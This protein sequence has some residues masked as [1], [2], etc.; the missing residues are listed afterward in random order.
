MAARTTEP[1]LGEL[2]IM[3]KDLDTVWDVARQSDAPV[4]MTATAL[5]LMRQ[6]VAR[7]EAHEDI[8]VLSKVYG[9]LPDK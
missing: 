1:K 5:G 8:G 4:P 9:D 6:I 3:V 2:A 7:G